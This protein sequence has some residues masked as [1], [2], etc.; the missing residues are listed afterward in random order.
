MS[1]TAKKRIVIVGLGAVGALTAWRLS[2]RRDVEVIGVEQYGRVHEHGSYAGESRVFRTAYHEGGRYVP[3]LQESRRLWRELESASGRELYLEVG[4]LSIAQA[5]RIEMRT[6]LDTVRDYA[7]PHTL[8]SAEELRRAYPQ[9][10]VHDGDVGVL[11][12]HGGGI[13][14]EVALLSALEL[15]ERAGAE[16][17]FNSPVLAIEEE[18]GGVVVRTPAEAIRAD[19]VVV[20][21]GS[22]ST[23][24][25]TRL[26]D[27][28]RLQVLGLTWFLPQSI[29]AFLPERFPA[30][31][32]DVGPVHFFGVPT[33]DGYSVKA[34]SNPTWP[35][36][37][38]VAEVPTAY[39]RA[40]LVKIGQQAQEFFPALNPEP[41]RSSV[42]HC[43]YTPD[44][45]PVV[46][47][48]DSGRVAIVTGLSGHGFKFAPVLGEWAARLAA[49]GERGDVDEHFA[50]D[51]HLE[52]LQQRGAYGGGGH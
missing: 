31:L 4:A 32:R 6:T 18:P 2:R 9:H 47:L 41:V 5:D 19:A 45:T 3:M 33:L 21:S 20:A 35:V 7:L 17:R 8:Y 38:D 39:T 52:R 23:R 48:S 36:A 44:R 26:H 34:C 1:T 12:H 11:D 27:L 42:H 37:R 15:A 49:T 43:A 30:F 29:D 14:S 50:L 24:L 40:E 28:L 13:R 51:A 16:L 10:A 25:D 46:D 22:W